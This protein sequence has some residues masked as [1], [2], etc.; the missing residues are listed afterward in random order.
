MTVEFLPPPPLSQNEKDYLRFSKNRQP[1][2][3]SILC[4]MDAI[5]VDLTP[6]WL[7]CIAKDTGV[8]ESIDNITQ[9]NLHKCGK[10]LPLGAK[11]VYDYLQKPG[12]FLNAPEIPTALDR[13]KQLS[14]DGHEI[15][16]LSSPSG[17]I[18]AKEKWE[19][20]NAKAP[21]IKNES[22]GLFNKKTMVQADV[23]IDDHPETVVKYAQKWPEALVLGIKYPYNTNVVMSDAIMVEGYKDYPLA[24][25]NIYSL[26]EAFASGV[27]Q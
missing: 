8:V 1:R 2:K 17:P 25:T 6:Y 22:I 26:I 19:W 21:W 18:S 9:W 16:I 23:L 3:L 4:D 27:V 20:L 11:V 14:E 10:L 24:W 12:F 13:L 5:L 7:E 15:T